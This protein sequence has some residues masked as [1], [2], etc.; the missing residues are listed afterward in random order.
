MDYIDIHCHV[1]SGVDDGA[2][3]PDES[4]MM[5][6]AMYDEGI[7]EAILTPHYHRGYAEAD[8]NK[9]R[10]AFNELCR[11][12]GKD[13]KASAIKLHLG[14]ELYYYPSAIQW[15]DEGKT[16]TMAGSRYVLLEF[17]YT[18]DKRMIYEGVSNV[19]R[20]GYTPI[21]AHVERYTGLEY[22][23]KNVADLL[24]MGALIQINAGSVGYGF[25][26]ERSF[27]RKLLRDH[28]VHFVATDAHD[29][30]KRAPRLAKAAEHIR[31]H[32]GEEYLQTILCDNP[33]N[34]IW[35]KG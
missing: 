5:L 6:R 24:E 32:F 23:V 1:L 22:K 28:M 26:K 13:E 21:I 20:A 35:S 19:V 2:Q 8:V 33:A 14:C 3:D 16:L 25:S 34:V 7:R 11:Y 30:D 15:L 18:M 29:T 10:S 27:A 31:K 9:I 17:G 4:V 12:A